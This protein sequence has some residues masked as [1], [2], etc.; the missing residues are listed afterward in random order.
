MFDVKWISYFF[1]GVAAIIHIGFFIMESFILQKKAEFSKDA[2]LWAFNQGFYNLFLAVGMIIGLYY[3]RQL[4]IRMAGM[5][6]SF[7]GLSMIVAGLVLAFSSPKLRKWSLIQ[8]VPP[9]IGFIFLGF[10]IASHIK[11]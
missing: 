3:V 4:E 11:G 9:L 10:H 1:F 6:V 7:S 5:M 8:I 2:K